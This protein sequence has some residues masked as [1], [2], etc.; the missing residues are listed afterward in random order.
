MGAGPVMVIFSLGGASL[1]AHGKRSALRCQ[2]SVLTLAAP[3]VIVLDPYPTSGAKGIVADGRARVVGGDAEVDGRPL[4]PPGRGRW[5]DLDVLSFAAATLFGW[6]VLPALLD[7]PA[8]AVRRLDAGRLDVTVPD[9]WPAGAERHVLHVDGDGLVR[10]HDEGHLVHELSGH[11]DFGGVV[12]ATRRRTRARVAGRL[13]PMHW[14]DVVAA[15]VLPEPAAH[16]LNEEP[17]AADT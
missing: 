11:C 1:A 15:H 6:I 3:P 12:V 7:D 17:P 2:P 16:A 13:V 5:D 4:G 8:L 14:A 10:R 9:G